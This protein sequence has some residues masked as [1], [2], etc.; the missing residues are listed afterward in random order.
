LAV[1]VVIVVVVNATL[2]IVIAFV[3]PGP[4]PGPALVESIRAVETAAA[5]G[6]Q[7]PHILSQVLVPASTNIH[8]H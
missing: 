6:L 1:L 7:M 2:K 8:L 4:G 3:T 5:A